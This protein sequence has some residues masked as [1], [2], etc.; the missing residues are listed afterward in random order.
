MQGADC[1]RHLLGLKLIAL[2]NGIPLHPLFASAGAAASGA[3]EL[4]TSQLPYSVYDH[5]G[6]GAPAA[7][8]YGV[9]YRFA[10]HSISGVVGSRNSCAEKDAKRFSDTIT[11]SALDVLSL[12][13]NLEPESKSKL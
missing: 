8:S 3:F 9:C 1:D 11:A 5:A 7:T 13:E 4:S 6:F 2:E 12:L 10:P